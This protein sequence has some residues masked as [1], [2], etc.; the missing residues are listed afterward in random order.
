MNLFNKIMY[1]DNESF[2]ARRNGVYYEVRLEN[3]VIALYHVKGFKDKQDALEFF[4]NQ[5][6]LK[7]AG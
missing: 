1:S 2:W 7:R 4:L 6:E 5:L 3:E